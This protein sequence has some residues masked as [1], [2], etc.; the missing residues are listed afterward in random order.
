MAGDCLVLIDLVVPGLMGFAFIVLAIVTFAVLA[1]N[2]R[3]LQMQSQNQP[4]QATL[5]NNGEVEHE[6]TGIPSS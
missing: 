2:R 4:L 5:S 1:E 3:L 6:S